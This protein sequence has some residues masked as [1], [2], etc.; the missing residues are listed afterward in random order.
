MN[1]KWNM[2]FFMFTALLACSLLIY[3]VVIAYFDDKYAEKHKI[4]ALAAGILGFGTALIVLGG[5][6]ELSRTMNILMRPYSGLSSTVISQ[7]VIGIT[8]VVIFAKGLKSP[9]L[10]IVA[11]IVAAASVYCLA[12]YYMMI[13]RPAL[14]TYILTAMFYVIVMLIASL[15]VN[16]ND[17]V[18]V[19]YSSVTFKLL[20]GLVVLFGLLFL[21][22]LLRIKG[23]SQEDRVFNLNN[24]VYGIYAPLVWTI[25]VLSFLIPALCSAMLMA[26]AR[27]VMMYVCGLS[28][29]SGLFVL[30]ILINQM[31][32]IKDAINGRNIF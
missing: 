29:I 4:N 5:L 21:L 26:R 7:L 19:K 13:A 11:C 22:F 18:Y 10:K 3:S 2:T 27:A 24:L 25:A 23:I 20:T 28:F 17:Q 9:L 32:V 31:P 8:G 16:M 30:S 6:N 15:L 1:T 12:R 14:D